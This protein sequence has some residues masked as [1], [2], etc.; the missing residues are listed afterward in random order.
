MALRC[1]QLSSM[2]ESIA[3]RVDVAVDMQQKANRVLT[4]VLGAQY[5][6][7]K[8]PSHTHDLCSKTSPFLQYL[9]QSESRNLLISSAPSACILIA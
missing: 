4:H 3:Q 2:S 6:L 5:T 9:C 8:Y 7:C 1:R